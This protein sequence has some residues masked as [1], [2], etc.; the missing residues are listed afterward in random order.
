MRDFDG[1]TV[2]VTGA[3]SG[4]GREVACRFAKEG[5]QVVVADID[6]AGAAETV[7]QA[8]G[9]G[10]V[11]VA[12]RTDVSDAAS[13]ELLVDFTI[14]RFGRIDVLHNNA[15]WAPLYTSLSDTTL[16]QW[17]H[18]IGVTLSGVFHGCKYALPHMVE[19]GGGV[20]VNTAS[21][22][23]LRVTP[24]FAAYMSAKGGV[25]ALTRSVAYDYG[26]QGI[27]CNAVAPG[28]ID[29]PATRDVF[30]NAER[31]EWLMSKTPLGRSGLVSDVANAV[32]FLASDEA[33]FMTG[34][35]VIVDGGRHIG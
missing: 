31:M 9:A 24:L 32:L 18:T 19:A 3:A 23:A 17:Q 13:V 34:E 6:E 25:I 35:T 5:A 8:E 26:K 11:A 27:R 28:L 16:E 15:V 30:E 29:T 10:G 21:V 7:A 22:A 20:I 4:I 1:R 33:S 14:E 2:I 12:V